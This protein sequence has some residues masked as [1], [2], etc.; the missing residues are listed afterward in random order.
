MSLIKNKIVFAKATDATAVP[1][2]QLH[3]ALQINVL[4]EIELRA[5]QSAP[6]HRVLWTAVICLNWTVKVSAGSQRNKRLFR[7]T[8]SGIRLFVRGNWFINS[9]ISRHYF[10]QRARALPS[11]TAALKHVLSPA[12]FYEFME[13]TENRTESVGP[14]SGAKT[15]QYPHILEPFIM[16]VNSSCESTAR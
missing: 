6:R 12:W 3:F 13:N 2:I 15:W 8:A 9:S 10:S 16:T 7:P 11:S 5:R 14:S 4:I 1:G